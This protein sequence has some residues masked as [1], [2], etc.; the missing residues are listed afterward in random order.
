M[1]WVRVV[2]FVILALGLS[3][4]FISDKPLLTPANADYSIPHGAVFIKSSIVRTQTEYEPF[5]NAILITRDYDNKVRREGGYYVHEETGVN[6]V[7]NV[8]RGL[9]KKI[10]KDNYLVM[11]EDKEE[12]RF[13]YGLFVREGEEWVQYKVLC[14]DLVFSA[15]R[16]VLPLSDFGAVRT[17]S[18]ACKFTSLERLMHAITFARGLSPKARAWARYKKAGGTPIE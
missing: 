16:A 18:G 13:W 5:D 8:S 11:G 2:G 10:D 9:M 3:G 12:G 17:P 14:E 15:K 7:K 6:G 4:C 1:L